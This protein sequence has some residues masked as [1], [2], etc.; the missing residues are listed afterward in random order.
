[1]AVGLNAVLFPVTLYHL[2]F[3]KTMIGF[4]LLMDI[5]AVIV[6]S[7]YISRIIVYAGIAR[8][9]ILS[10]IIRSLCLAILS[11]TGNYAVWCICIFLFGMSTNM[12]LISLQTWI[13]SIE[14][15][16][17]KGLIIGIYSSSI[18]L[19]TSIGPIIINMTG[20]GGKLPFIANIIIVLSTIIP[21]LFIYKS[22][23]KIKSSPKP[24]VLYSIKLSKVPMLSAFAGGIT[25]YGLPYFL[26]IYGTMN[27]LSIERSAYL[28]TAFMLGSV[29]LGLLI[30]SISDRIDRLKV[31][32]VCVA[33]GLI[34]AIYLPMAIYNYLQALILLFIWGGV[35]GGIY[36]TGLARVGEMFR[37]EDQISANLAYSLMDCIGGTI[38]IF[39][40]G[41]CMDHLGSDGL[42]YVIV[43]GAIMFFMFTLKEIYIVKE[44]NF[45][46]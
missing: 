39:L 38:G 4:C 30:A 9:L 1:M 35:S 16:N 7:R 22:V 17:Y 28:I 33:V 41:L 19:G 40:I 2:G 15:K 21:L 20:T 10:T 6:I 42:I 13:N 26:T 36:A 23:P 31:I 5:I 18:S 8:I 43:S 14:I 25:F 46:M 32:M 3:S 11:G 12:M 34:S 45:E 37:I 29:I 24:R 44:E 27:K